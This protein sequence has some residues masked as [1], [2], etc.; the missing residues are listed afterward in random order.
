MPTEEIPAIK[1]LSKGT[2]LRNNAELVFAG[3]IQEEKTKAVLVTEG[4]LVK[5]VSIADVPILDKKKIGVKVGKLDDDKIV[6]VKLIDNSE[7]LELFGKKVPS[8]SLKVEKFTTKF[9]KIK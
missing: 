8:K 6:S 1:H 9:K 7:E 4:G 3:S 5:T 2:S